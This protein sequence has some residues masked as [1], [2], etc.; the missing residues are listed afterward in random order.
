VGLFA[1]LASTPA[2]ATVTIQAMTPSKASPQPL[3]TPITWLVK[4]T[5]SS[6][7]DL[8]FNFS[9]ATSTGT[10][11]A[12]SAYNIGVNSAGSWTSQP[13]VWSSINGEGTYYIQ[14]I[15][16]DFVT[17]ES[18]TKTTAYQL[19]SRVAAGKAVVHS[20]DNVLVAVF[21]APACALGS[22][23]RVAFYPTSNPSNIN[24][25]NTKSCTGT[26]SMNFYVAGMYPS[27]AY[28]MYSQTMTGT[29]TVNGAALSLTT[30]A[31]PSK[32]KGG[33]F[34]TFAQSVAPPGNDPNP[35][36][37]WAFTK[38]IVPVATDLNG[39]IMW[40]YGTGN[41][42]LL[43]RPVGGSNGTTMLTIQNGQS[44]DS[45]NDVQQILAEID[46]GGNLIRQ[47][48]TGIISNQLVAM[49]ATDATPCGQIIQ[50]PKVGDACLN[51]FH[52]DAIRL[53][54]G[55]TALLAHIEKLFPPGTQG[56][57]TGDPVDIL[58]EMVI[59]VN[60]DWQVVW[61]YDA[62]DELN[63]NRVAPLGE[64]CSAG[65]S[66]CPTDLFLASVCN[67]WT[68]GN[69][70]D[71]VASTASP[72]YG[73][74]L[75]SMRDQD[76]VI[77]I[78]YNNGAGTCAPTAPNCIVWAMGPPDELPPSNFNFDN[79]YNDPWP[80]YSHQHDA[81]YSNAGAPVTLNNAT[82]GLL[83]IFDNGNTRF[84]S[85]PLGLG[86]PGCLPNDCDSRGMALIVTQEPVGDCA[87]SCT[88]G[89]VVPI[90]SQGVGLQS[91]ALG[92][93]QTLSNGNYF[94]QSG[95]SETVTQAIE[96]LPVVSVPPTATQVM[97]VTS[98]DYSYRGWQM[99]NLYNPPT[100]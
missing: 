71:F 73:D 43:L 39:K 12:F 47:T 96:Y 86:S 19:V 24:Y 64:T 77:R 48:N 10:L 3:G 87:T 59:V 41:S 88:P 29:K 9:V 67:D 42:P 98:V 50:P 57:N 54:N 63:I 90:I 65:A 58:G 81:T 35:M 31:L 21:S 61:Y 72:D 27:T 44:W 93:A 14:V 51:D 33:L 18:A 45:T 32:A 38:I 40:Y 22:T 60:A 55:D 85:P 66:D 23:M 15:V 52:H 89:T 95:I 26:I 99:P 8:T 74:F 5:D 84:A 100:L 11:I 30:A 4:A 25:T 83:T 17:G 68:H 75:V 62:F 37:L 97:N 56:S 80:W 76:Q 34:P 91:T 7:N 20:S 69:T 2:Y 28:I 36:L 49:G 46:L 82:G 78:H 16:K 1:A 53:P 70:V 94:F 6:S 13:F 92:G 79:L